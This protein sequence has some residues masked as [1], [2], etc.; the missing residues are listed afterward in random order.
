MDA[1]QANLLSNS[2]GFSHFECFNELVRRVKIEEKAATI[3]IE[4]HAAALYNGVYTQA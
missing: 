1:A 3:T 4:N 2:V